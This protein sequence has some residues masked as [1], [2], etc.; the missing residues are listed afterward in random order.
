MSGEAS[1]ILGDGGSGMSRHPNHDG[2]KIVLR[3]LAVGDETSCL[4]DRVANLTSFQKLADLG[5]D[6]VPD[7]VERRV[8][9]SIDGLGGAIRASALEDG[10]GISAVEV[11]MLGGYTVAVRSST[12]VRDNVGGDSGATVQASLYGMVGSK[13]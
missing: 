9:D 5:S 10:C 3:V 11:G 4:D 2:T 13:T 8:K 12:P 7:S 1:C 6:N